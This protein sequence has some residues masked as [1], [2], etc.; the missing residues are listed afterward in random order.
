MGS[1]R[2]VNLAFFDA[3]ACSVPRS[4]Y[5]LSDGSSVIDLAKALQ[6]AATPLERHNPLIRHDANFIWDIEDEPK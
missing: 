6:R 3:L 5:L 1:R 4:T 2:N